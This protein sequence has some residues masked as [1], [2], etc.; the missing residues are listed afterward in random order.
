MIYNVYYGG[1]SQVIDKS[2][3]SAVTTGQGIRDIAA[4]VAIVDNDHPIAMD[5]G[6]SIASFP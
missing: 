5:D 3:W 4:I 1:K 6:H 2:L